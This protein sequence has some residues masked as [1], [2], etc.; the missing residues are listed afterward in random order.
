M[1][2]FCYITSLVTMNCYSEKKNPHWSVLIWHFFSGINHTL[3]LGFLILFF[4]SSRPLALK[5][6]LKSHRMTNFFHSKWGLREKWR[7]FSENFIILNKL[8]S[9]RTRAREK[10]DQK[11]RTLDLT[12]V[13]NQRLTAAIPME[14]DKTP[15]KL[16]RPSS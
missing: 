4:S 8:E 16:P 11:I 1:S 10:K 14:L 9:K 13:S 12:G 6:S 7:H 3:G 2:V 5:L 15:L